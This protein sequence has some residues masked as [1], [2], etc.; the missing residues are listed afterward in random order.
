[1]GVRRVTRFGRAR[2]HASICV[3]GGTAATKEDLLMWMSAIVLAVL[4]LLLFV[5]VASIWWQ[6]P[7]SNQSQE[8]LPCPNCRSRAVN[9][10]VPTSGLAGYLGSDFQQWCGQCRACQYQGPATN[11]QPTAEQAWNDLPR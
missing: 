1:M 6:E 4:G 3:G 2:R 10:C 11:A 5:I 8:L 7:N 9:V